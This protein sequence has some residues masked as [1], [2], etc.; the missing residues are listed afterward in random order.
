MADNKKNSSK[1]SLVKQAEAKAEQMVKE[2]SKKTKKGAKK[3]N[4]FV[5]FFKDLKSELK[6]VV[7]P[8]KQKVI[9]N[10]AIVLVAMSIC[11]V[12]IWAIDSGLAALLKLGLGA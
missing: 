8:S 5:K 12:A 6:K 1:K 2:N 10:T 3:Q 9:N 7:W 11:S 4:R